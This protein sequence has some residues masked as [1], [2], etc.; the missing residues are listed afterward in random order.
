M[1]VVIVGFGLFYWY[2]IRPVRISKSCNST[3]VQKAQADYLV[4]I[5][6]KALKPA[7]KGYL[8]EYQYTED[9]RNAELDAATE[10]GAYNSWSYENYYSNCLKVNGI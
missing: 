10:N 8:I 5:K 1:T 9:D 3:S 6:D 7:S 2:E 4:S